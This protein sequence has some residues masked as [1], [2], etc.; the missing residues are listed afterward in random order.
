[1]TTTE[2]LSFMRLLSAMESAMLI[3]KTPM[4]D[5]IYEDVAR[6]VGILEREILERIKT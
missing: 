5:H 1:M 6:H 4:P 2:L 3:A